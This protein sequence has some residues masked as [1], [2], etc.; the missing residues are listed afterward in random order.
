MPKKQ[1]YNKDMVPNS[2]Y[3]SLTN[4]ENEI[5]RLVDRMNVICFKHVDTSWMSVHTSHRVAPRKEILPDTVRNKTKDC[6]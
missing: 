2:K 4:L 3:G 5:F 6:L 1:F